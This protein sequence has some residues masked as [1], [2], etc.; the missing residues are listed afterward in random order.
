MVSVW[1]TFSTVPA[2]SSLFLLQD[3]DGKHS[4]QPGDADA[5]GVLSPTGETEADEPQ[6]GQRRDPQAGQDCIADV[7]LIV[8]HHGCRGARWRKSSE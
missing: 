6:D 5:R 1:S 4:F 8:G 7:L 2:Q 3:R